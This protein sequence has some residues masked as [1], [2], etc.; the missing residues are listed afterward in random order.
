MKAIFKN[1]GPV[2]KAELE[3]KDLTIIAGPNNTGKTY[4]AYTLYG[5]LKM[6]QNP[7]FLRQQKVIDLPLEP[8]KALQVILDNFDHGFSEP[9]KKNS[10]LQV[11]KILEIIRDS[12]FEPD[13]EVVQDILDSGTAQFPVKDFDKTAQ[14]VFDSAFLK[15]AEP[16]SVILNS[17]SDDFKEADFSFSPDYDRR[18]TAIEFGWDRKGDFK[19]TASFEKGILTFHLENHQASLPSPIIKNMIDMAFIALCSPKLPKPFILASE[20]LG[21]SLFYKELDFTKSRLLEIFQ[22]MKDRENFKN[23]KSYLLLMDHIS[24]RYAQPIKDNINYARDLESV[25]KKRALLFDSK[26]FDNIKE[27]LGGYFKYEGYG[28]RFISKA[29]KNGQFNIS[30]HS[31]SSSARGL[32]D[33]YFFLKHT[34]HENQLLIIDEPESHLD[35]ANQIEMARLLARCVNSGLKVLITTHSDYIIKEFNNLIMLSH[36]FSGKEKFLKKYSNVYGEHDYLKQESVA[37]YI[38]KNGALGACE[39]DNLGLNMP[40]FDRTIDQINLI[41]NELALS[42]EN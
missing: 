21:I 5:F 10:L 30:L 19:L 16:I 8:H 6:A 14:K 18:E 28:V 22:K 1:I 20:R 41:A 11:K 15:T 24:S 34:A 12:G 29:R 35:T 37:A 33:L 32:C 7:S 36:D 27:M 42:V 39:V 40:N 3:L 23:F 26:L 2:K 25:Q 9:D 38:C 4:L 13:D 17:P 31:A